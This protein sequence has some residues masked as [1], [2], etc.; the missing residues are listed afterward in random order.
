MDSSCQVSLAISLF[1][2]DGGSPHVL[3]GTDFCP[4]FDDGEF[5]KAVKRLHD[6][7]LRVYGQKDLH[8]ANAAAE[9][10]LEG[11][12]R[13]GVSVKTQKESRLREVRLSMALT[14]IELAAASGVGLSTISWLENETREVSRQKKIKVA[15]F[16]SLPI[17]ELFPVKDSRVDSLTLDGPEE[18]REKANLEMTPEA[19]YARLG[20]ALH[21]PPEDP[22]QELEDKRNKEFRKKE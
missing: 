16:L 12:Q 5:D 13:G 10:L 19:Y 14:Q 21:R 2:G 9:K 22:P 3:P 18:K 20:K 11:K 6:E 17:D 7:V 4:A 1:L 15:G 8:D